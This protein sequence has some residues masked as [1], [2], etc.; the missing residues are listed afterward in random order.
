M[1]TSSVPGSNQSIKGNFY[2][3][4]VEGIVKI[5]HNES[6]SI[7]VISREHQVYYLFS[8][9]KNPDRFSHQ[10]PSFAGRGNLTNIVN[11]MLT[12]FS[13]SPSASIECILFILG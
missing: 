9:R 5:W 6:M 12:D 1:E 4:F 8:F 13:H 3:C 11:T 7:L 10:V 2:P